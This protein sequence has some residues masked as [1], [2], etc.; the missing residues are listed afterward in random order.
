MTLYRTPKKGQKFFQNYSD[1]LSYFPEYYQ[2]LYEQYMLEGT[3]EFLSEQ[4]LLHLTMFEPLYD[5]YDCLDLLPGT[6][7]P[8]V[9]TLL[10]SA[11]FFVVAAMDGLNPKASEESLAD[12][13]NH[14]KLAGVLFV[15]SII[16]LINNLLSVITRPIAT[17]ILGWNSGLEERFAYEST[18]ERVSGWIFRAY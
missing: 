10:A 11:C 16:G 7:V 13:G 17:M 8:S 3:N 1:H 15:T 6:V 18:I 5:R 4:F 14:L 9:V 2:S 12:V